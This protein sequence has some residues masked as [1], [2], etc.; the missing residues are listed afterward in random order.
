MPKK[1]SIGLTLGELIDK[2]YALRAERLALTQQADDMK[3]DEDAIRTTILGML[4]SV[5][6]TAGKGSVAQA[7]IK[8]SLVPSL[9]DFDKFFN[10]VVRNKATDLI[11]RQV[12]ATAIRER[13]DA[14]KVVAGVE[15]LEVRDIHLTKI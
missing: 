11:R 13:W 12:N 6:L 5:D 1:Q 2:L 10:Y 3:K 7:S 14:G 15:P 4:D 9:Q 8:I